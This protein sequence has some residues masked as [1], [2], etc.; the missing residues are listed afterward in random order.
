MEDLYQIAELAKSE[1]SRLLNDLASDD[2][3]SQQRL[4]YFVTNHLYNVLKRDIEQHHSREQRSRQMKQQ[5]DEFIQ[6]FLHRDKKYYYLSS[7]GLFIC[8]EDTE[9]NVISEDHI[10]MEVRS[11]LNAL[12]NEQ[13]FLKNQKHSITKQIIKHIKDYGIDSSVPDSITLQNVINQ[14]WP[15]IF[16]TRDEVKYFLTVIGDALSKKITTQNHNHTYF[17]PSRSKGFLEYIC[18]SLCSLKGGSATQMLALFKSKVQGHDYDKTRFIRIK[19]S[20]LINSYPRITPI[21]LL[22]VSCHYSCTYGSAE[23]FL[24]QKQDKSLY[25]STKVL[26][27][28]NENTLI[29]FF[30]SQCLSI[31]MHKDN[32]NDNNLDII[33]SHSLSFIW[34]KFLENRDMPYVVCSIPLLQCVT[35]CPNMNSF[36]N[37]NKSRFEGITSQLLPSVICFREFWQS[38][39]TYVNYSDN[40]NQIIELDELNTLFN[41]WIRTNKNDISHNIIR[42]CHIEDEQMLEFI[43][44]YF[45]DTV[46][47]D[48]K[49]IMG[50]RSSMWDKEKDVLRFLDGELS[51]SPKLMGIYY[52]V[53]KLYAK[54]CS[55]SKVNLLCT[56]SKGYFTQILDAM[57]S[58]EV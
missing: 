11:F 9:Y 55:F 49:F 41:S 53:D 58:Y 28:Y 25:N 48:D 7:S 24:T 54:Y 3:C 37:E 42:Q 23:E 57:F 35:N 4:K 51:G 34:K 27:A 31:S 18:K 33:D 32:I 26:S 47:D 45:P 22:F 14:L 16:D 15:S 19:R 43:K 6:S 8:Y 39:I 38:T 13:L 2:I 5:S 36:Y 56:A 1:C 44:H 20:G 50:I 40:S 21:N 17:V 10:T 30:V 29:D 12:P 52:D 46:I